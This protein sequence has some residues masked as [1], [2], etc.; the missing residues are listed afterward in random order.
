MSD[1]LSELNTSEKSYRLLMR[2]LP[3]T[4]PMYKMII[5]GNINKKQ[6]DQIFQ[7]CSVATS[8]ERKKFANS[9]SI[10]LGFN[11]S[12]RIV[13]Q[14]KKELFI[15]YKMRKKYSKVQRK[16]FETSLL[17][18][19]SEEKRSRT[20]GTEIKNILIALN[21]NELFAMEFENYDVKIQSIINSL[22]NSPQ[23]YN[24]IF[25]KELRKLENKNETLKVSLEGIRRKA[26]FNIKRIDD[27]VYRIKN[28]KQRKSL[29]YEV[30]KDEK[31]KDDLEIDINEL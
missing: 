6:L 11:T 8:I 26:I 3:K 15:R 21:H 22:I 29:Q 31:S 24:A 13:R 17:M 2:A 16:Y 1:N 12:N 19:T 9:F 4:N 23:K 27:Q 28:G 30:A 7:A 25:E 18:G 20:I 5:D 14:I 10:L